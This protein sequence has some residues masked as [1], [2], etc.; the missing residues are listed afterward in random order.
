MALILPQPLADALWNHALRDAPSECVGALGGIMQGSDM[1]SDM[2]SDTKIKTLYPLTNISPQPE[3]EYLA[4]PAGL[5]RALR[6]MEREG[7]SLVALYHSHPNGPALPSATDLRLAMYPV[8]YL[9]ADIHSHILRAYLLP[10]QVAI[11]LVIN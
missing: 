8:P 4:D 5:L 11:E 7:L 2:G 3:R 10:N 1:G 9:I 6:G